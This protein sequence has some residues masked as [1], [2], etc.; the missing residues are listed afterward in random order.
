MGGSGPQKKMVVIPLW[1]RLENNKIKGPMD[2]LKNFMETYHK[3]RNVDFRYCPNADERCNSG[4]CNAFKADDKR[5]NFKFIVHVP[6]II[7][8]T[9]KKAGGSGKGKGGKSSGKGKGYRR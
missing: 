5:T 9:G 2:I 1:L 3:E 7:N 8:Q 4:I 6:H